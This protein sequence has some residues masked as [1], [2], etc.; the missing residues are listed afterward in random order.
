MPVRFDFHSPRSGARGQAVAQ[1]V[2]D[3]GLE[4]QVWNPRLE[5][6]IRNEDP[7]AQAP[8][9]AGLLDLEIVLEKGDFF[10]ER[11]LMRLGAVEREAQQRA[12]PQEDPICCV[13]I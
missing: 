2:L 10:A 9:E 7:V 8:A 5:N 13:D 4:D 11:H 1:R 12:E 3:E 6:L